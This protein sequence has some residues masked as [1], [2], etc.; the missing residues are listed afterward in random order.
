M[1]DTVSKSAVLSE[2]G[3]YRY[4]LYRSWSAGPFVVFLMFNPSTADAKE[5]DPT[6]RKCI[7]FARRWKYPGLT[8]VNL[9]ALR[10]TDP[11]AIGRALYADAVGPDND[12]AILTACATA[13]EVISAWGCGQHMKSHSDRPAKVL[14]MV[15]A[16]YPRLAIQC[17]GR[18]S[19]G[20]PRHP[21]M[22]AYSTERQPFEAATR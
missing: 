11:R 16:T 22:L 5:D 4:R 18:S 13:K 1:T 6:I 19:D 7:G 20:S 3:R 15:R 9:F 2:C 14:R 21:L 10:S 12:E 17:L 8:V